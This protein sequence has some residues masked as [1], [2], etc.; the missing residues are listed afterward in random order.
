M[1]SVTYMK[2][3]DG[4]KVM[5]TRIFLD[6]DDVLNSFTLPALA[7]V[8]C[9]VGPFDYEGYN[10]DCG[11]DIVRA[12]NAMHRERAFTQDEFWSALS[13]EFWSSAPKSHECDWLCDLCASLV[14]KRNVFVLTAAPQKVGGHVASAKVS[15]IY[16]NLPDW[17]HAQFLIGSC[18][19]ACA[20]PDALL[21][22]D[23]DVNVENFK[24]AGGHAILVPRPWNSL[25]AR[26]T[27]MYII[28]SVDVLFGPLPWTPW[29][30]G[31]A[32]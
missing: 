24:R 28:Q 17:L 31:G 30:K 1:H 29:T 13:A 25:W 7:E 9:Q 18:K 26:L 32:A 19:Q 20:S 4:T 21:I 16:D 22:D 14:G 23:S 27:D 10:P 6:L 5:I 12:A 8:G 15:W 2:S 3:S 11:F